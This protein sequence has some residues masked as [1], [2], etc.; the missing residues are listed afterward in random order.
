MFDSSLNLCF[1]S[2]ERKQRAR[3]TNEMRRSDVRYRCNT[4]PSDTKC[5]SPPPL[6]P[7][8]SRE[9]SRTKRKKWQPQT[10]TTHTCF[11]CV[12]ASLSMSG[13]LGGCVLFS[14]GNGMWTGENGSVPWTMTEPSHMIAEFRRA[15]NTVTG[16][17]G[18]ENAHT[19]IKHSP[20]T[21]ELDENVAS[22][23]AYPPDRRK[24]RRQCAC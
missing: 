7:R 14:P 6:R 24:S 18:P 13:S 16:P 19:H 3:H 11:S 1:S 22:G 4:R 5:H 2:S 12:T 21:G 20:E 23:G 10:S 15:S 9:T 17:A 8:N